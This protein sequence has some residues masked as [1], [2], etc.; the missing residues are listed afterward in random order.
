MFRVKQEPVVDRHSIGGG[1]EKLTNY[2]DRDRHPN[3]VVAP[4]FRSFRLRFSR[5]GRASTSSRPCEEGEGRELRLPS[6]M[7]IAQ[8]DERSLRT[9]IACC[10][11]CSPLN[12]YFPLSTEACAH[13]R[14]DTNTVEP[15]RN[16]KDIPGGGPAHN[17]RIFLCLSS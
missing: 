8:G 5:A 11:G 12:H 10:G 9:N 15:R 4:L 7:A 14:K 16:S 1:R 6:P 3:V 2:N 17:D 13:I